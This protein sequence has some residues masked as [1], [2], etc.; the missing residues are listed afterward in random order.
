MSP[1]SRCGAWPLA[2][3]AAVALLLSA[4]T[5]TSVPIPTG[6]SAPAPTPQPPQPTPEPIIAI[7]QPFTEPT[8]AVAWVPQEQTLVVRQ[9]AGLSSVGVDSF[10][11]DQGGIRLTGKTTLLGS[12]QWVE[13]YRND[14]GTGWVNGWNLTEEVSPEA[15]CDDLR[16]LDLLARLTQALTI[17]A[18]DRLAE[19]VSPGRG[20]IVR[21]DAWNPE[22]HFEPA[23]V[24]DLFEDTS[25]YD[26]GI[27]R[28][29]QVPILGT[30]SEIILPKLETVLNA[31][32]EVSCNLLGV[33]SSAREPAWP[34]E[35]QNLN[36][37]SFYR[38]APEPGNRL[39][40]H[41]WAVGVEYVAGQPY[42][43][44]LVHFQGEI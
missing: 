7:I 21:H 28:D 32:P 14:G 3:A 15:F 38:R 40:W 4:C 29:S 1:S 42:V 39:N 23:A 13:V 34:S 30:F 25:Q 43:A 5:R 31:A 12:S 8:Y 2:R 6:A 24:R 33:G 37:Y 19:L 18:G 26:W 35:Y 11:A 36:F 44:V 10:P 9:P 20:L 16:V 27:V 17:R 41:T 22:V